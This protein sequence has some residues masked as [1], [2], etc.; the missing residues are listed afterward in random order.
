MGEAYRKELGEII[1]EFCING[2]SN[3]DTEW[4][5]VDIR[6]TSSVISYNLKDWEQDGEIFMRED[7]SYVIQ[8]MDRWIQGD[9]ATIEK[10]EAIEPDLLLKFYPGEERRI[11]FCICLQT[12]EKAFTHNYIVLL[13]YGKKAKEFVEYWKMMASRL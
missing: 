6:I 11:D 5:D 13:L 4:V 12:K 7:I 1:L 10:Y 9:M 3:H 2:M 8:L